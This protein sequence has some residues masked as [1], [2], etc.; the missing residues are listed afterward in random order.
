[1]VKT[2]NEFESCEMPVGAI[3]ESYENKFCKCEWIKIQGECIADAVNRPVGNYVIIET[4]ILEH[5]SIGNLDEIAKTVSEYLV[6]MM[7]ISNRDSVLVVGIGNRNSIADSLGVRVADRIWATRHIAD[8]ANDRFGKILRPVSVITPGVTVVTGICT[9]EIIKNTCDKI[10]PSLVILVDAMAAGKT[11]WLNSSIQIKDTGIT[12]S[13]GICG[14]KDKQK[15]D[16]DFLGV[17]VVSI[18]VPTVTNAATIIMDALSL[19]SHKHKDDA[20]QDF[21]DNEWSD[22]L[23]IENIKQSTDKLF[24]SS[25]TLV[26]TMEIDA[27]VNYSSYIIS[28]AINNALFQ[29]DWMLMSHIDY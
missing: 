11:L 8:E 25:S 14:K 28:T 19:L 26:A 10:K 5:G 18:G 9:S 27:V 29:E 22:D 17:P 1:M 3:V 12:P 21:N 23:K 20:P 2:K 24:I 6:K 15:I 13:S 7:S 16:Y 4:N